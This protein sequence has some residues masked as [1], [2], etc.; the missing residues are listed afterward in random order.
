MKIVE[1]INSVL[2]QQ[3]NKFYR[4]RQFDRA[5]LIYEQILNLDSRNA[6]VWNNK[7]LCLAN[8]ARHMEAVFC[9]DKALNINPKYLFA[10]RNLSHSLI[11]LGEYE[12]A[13]KA[14]YK[15]LEIDPKNV[16][17]WS[18]KTLCENE[19]IKIS[20]EK[21]KRHENVI[22]EKEEREKKREKE[23]K[24]FEKNRESYSSNLRKCLK[25]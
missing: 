11:K 17:D 23:L 19:L 13:L 14:I 22:R 7:G 25:T 1:K 15:V 12:N 5:V 2:E 3:A 20:E 10:L 9:F 16:V 24:E 8:Q 18:N 6:R 21:M 4:A